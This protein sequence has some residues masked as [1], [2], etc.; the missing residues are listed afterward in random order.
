MPIFK[1]KNAPIFLNSQSIFIIFQLC[2]QNNIPQNQKGSS[3]DCED[4]NFYRLP[5]HTGHSFANKPLTFYMNVWH[6]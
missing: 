1:S 6:A 3:N 5:L 4:I 2:G